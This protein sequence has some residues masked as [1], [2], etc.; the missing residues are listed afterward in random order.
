[1]KLGNVKY[2]VADAL[3][4]PAAAL[5]IRFCWPSKNGKLLTVGDDELDKADLTD[6]RT[7]W[8]LPPVDS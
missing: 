8:E 7:V 5:E 6:L 3:R 2:H 4:I 1:M